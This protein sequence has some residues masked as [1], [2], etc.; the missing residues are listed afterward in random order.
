MSMSHYRGHRTIQRWDVIATKRHMRQKWRHILMRPGFTGNSEHPS[1]TLNNGIKSLFCT[2][3][4]LLHT[5][6][7]PQTK[8]EKKERLFALDPLKS[9]DC[10]LTDQSVCAC[11]RGL[12]C[13]SLCSVEC[14]PRPVQ[15]AHRYQMPPQS[16]GAAPLLLLSAYTPCSCSPA[17]L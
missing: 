11:F 7:G 16:M 9:K 4:H 1:I 14:F 5:L 2:S 17:Y 15:K 13:L 10:S 6:F 3:G 8:G 12:L